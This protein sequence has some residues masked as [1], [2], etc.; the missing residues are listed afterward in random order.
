MKLGLKRA[1]KIGI[2]GLMQI[3]NLLFK[4][5]KQKVGIPTLIQK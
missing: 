2:K 3:N 4:L 5:P 1:N